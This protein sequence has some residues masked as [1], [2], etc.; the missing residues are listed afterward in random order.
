MAPTHARRELALGLLATA[1]LTYANM[2]E[3]LREQKEA[4]AHDAASTLARQSGCHVVFPGLVTNPD[5]ARAA[6]AEFRKSGIGALVV[7]PTIAATANIPW[8]AVEACRRPT[9]IW[10]RFDP[11]NL[12]RDPVHGVYNSMPVG[13][14]AI[15]NVLMR[16]NVD[17]LSCTGP[18][19]TARAL[20]FL[21]AAG[22]AAQLDGGK[23]AHFGEESFPGMLDVLLDPAAL[24]ERLGIRIEHV[25]IAC[26]ANATMMEGALAEIASEPNDVLASERSL[27]LAAGMQI[28]ADNDKFVAASITCHGPSFAR[29]ADVGVVGCLGAS[30]LFSRGIP[31]ACTGDD[32]TAVALAIANLL[33]GAAHYCEFDTPY[34]EADA[35][36]VSNGGEGDIRMARDNPPPK[37]RPNPVFPGIAGNGTAVD[38]VLR[39]GPYTAIN[40]TPDPGGFRIIV[41]E[42][43]VLE[44]LPI[45]EGLPRGL[46]RFSVPASL[47]FDQWLEAGANH[48]LALAPG[49]HGEVLRHF[50]MLK[51]LTF[52]HVGLIQCVP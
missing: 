22:L 46:F 31:V 25:S 32:C 38:F 9:L 45:L 36:L 6:A 20:I 23:I 14:A 24:A 29:N 42:G 43:E 26:P 49:H 7:L 27:R 17:F 44:D 35:L 51:R 52:R 15:G 4:W 2:P 21:R 34:L 48:H 30:M 1:T 50:A 5:E 37:L 41:A 12:A 10:T 28:A 3:D 47:G 33:G 18:Q 8:A 11:D 39:S 40:F 19:L 13:A 16:E